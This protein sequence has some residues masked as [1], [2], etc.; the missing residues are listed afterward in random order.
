MTKLCAVVGGKDTEDIFSRARDALDSG[1]DMVE[2][3][4]D[5]FDSPLREIPV[6]K[7]SYRT[8]P[9]L[10][11]DEVIVTVRG[12]AEGGQFPSGEDERLA[13][14]SD[15][16]ASGAAWVDIEG[17]LAEDRLRRLVDEARGVGSK[18]LLSW[19][20][21]AT[22]PEDR[23]G[24]LERALGAFRD[25]LADMVKLVP[26]G[27]DRK[28]LDDFLI[29]AS[30]LDGQKVPH[31]IVPDPPM[32]LIGRMLGPMTGTEWVYVLPR[33]ISDPRLTRALPHIDEIAD[34]WTRMGLGGTEEGTVRPRPTLVP[35]KA[36]DGWTLLAI[37]GDPVSHTNSPVVHHSALRA[38]GMEGAYVPYRT[39]P[40][41]V[42]GTLDVL[43]SAGA[44]GCNVTV[45]LKVEALE[46]MDL[47]GD[48][49]RR[50][51][52]VNT[53]IFEDDGTTR[54]ENTDT[55]GV[56]ISAGELLGERGSGMTA[57]VLGTGGAARGAVVGLVDWGAQ[58]VATGRD[59]EHLEA[60]LG[61]LNGMSEAIPPE[62][63]DAIEGKVDI[64]V[65]CTS[66]GMQGVG[67]EGPVVPK[68]VWRMVGSPPVLDMVY[69]PGGTE[70][71][72]E[73]RSAGVPAAG[74]ERPLLHQ[75]AVGFALW[76]GRMAPLEDMEKA[77]MRVIEG[78]GQ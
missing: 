3:R 62:A 34:A 48:G 16:C 33:A 59:R 51:G 57:L 61:D 67:P 40:G 70:L 14:L 71:V 23:W 78:P 53:V 36:R 45:P 35:A 31:V 42:I 7:D 47:L 29:M 21:R 55:D 72:R 15:A 25:G 8:Q 68:E 63:L 37:L 69:F 27:R 75:A 19:H 56:R 20:G 49:A 46:A 26:T 12:P 24:D 44:L 66:Q 54:G 13:A 77:L 22:E 32:S 52:A 5:L 17:D 50:S 10:A 4:L 1:A 64:I 39:R 60:M 28:A 9:S 76:T 6:F 41:M 18:V 65:Q 30:E 38:L 73:A 11:N 43:R 2:L 58:V 74:G